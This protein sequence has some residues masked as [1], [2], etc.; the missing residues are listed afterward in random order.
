[1]LVRPSSAWSNLSPITPGL[2]DQPA[3]ASCQQ[4]FALHV[5]EVDWVVVG[6]QQSVCGNG[7]KSNVPVFCSRK[8]TV[9]DIGIRWNDRGRR[10]YWLSAYTH[11][12]VPT[13]CKMN[14]QAAVLAAAR[15]APHGR[16]IS[17]KI[18]KSTTVPPLHCV[19]CCC[20]HVVFRSDQAMQRY[21][22]TMEMPFL[23]LQY[24]HQL[25]TELR[26]SYE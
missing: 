4:T 5:H 22:R 11:C 17:Q 15:P 19:C 13:H 7:W 1:M 9:V 14:Q 3:A 18:S 25:G 23:I 20:C 8:C 12:S 10:P 21:A 24:D 16:L 26:D 2:L 6:T